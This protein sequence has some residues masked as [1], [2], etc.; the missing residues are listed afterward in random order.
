MIATHIHVL[1]V[2]WVYGFA[3]YA[4]GSWLVHTY[5]LD[6]CFFLFPAPPLL[7]STL[8]NSLLFWLLVSPSYSSPSL[9]LSLVSSLIWC[10]SFLTLYSGECCIYLYIYIR[11]HTVYVCTAY[12]PPFAYITLKKIARKSKWLP[13]LFPIGPKHSRTERGRER[14]EMRNGAMCSSWER[15]VGVYISE[16]KGVYRI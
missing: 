1:Y 13:L 6:S 8:I 16:Y 9:S 7:H 3:R 11:I 12:I 10:T 5:I 2:P 4:A 14:R 15:A